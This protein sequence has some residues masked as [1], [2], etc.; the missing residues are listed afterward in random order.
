MGIFNGI[1]DSKAFLKRIVD[2]FTQVDNQKD[3][4]HASKLMRPDGLALAPNHK[5]LF[6]VYFTLGDNIP[7]VVQGDSGLIGALVKS[8]QLPSFRL[9]TKEYIQYN[10]KRLVHNRIEYDPVTI[11]FHDDASDTIR[12]LWYNYF[13]YYFADPSY[14]YESG[15]TP[16]E[17]GKTDYTGRDLYDPR[18]PRQAAGWGI[19]GATPD[20]RPVK[21]AFFKDI[22]IYGL[23][24]GNYMSYTLINPVITAWRHDTFDYSQS[25]GIMEHEMQLK[26]EAVKY[27]SGK[28]DD[29]G[30]I[31]VKGFAKESRY[32]TVPGV[33]GK[34][35]T[36]QIDINGNPIAGI[37][38]LGT[39]LASGNYLSALR[40]GLQGKDLLQGD[41]L[42][43]AIAGDLVGRTAS[44]L[45]NTQFD[46]PKEE[47][48]L[49]TFST[50]STPSA[51]APIVIDENE[52]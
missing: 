33:L 18:R 30:E 20:G 6:H 52:I 3:Y 26:Y 47:E 11:K 27:G 44:L 51:E 31:N 24:R 21:P 17:S 40:T 46:F 48:I 32:D 14:E 12:S 9:D 49:N 39:D 25:A 19:T 22:T 37:N 43:N 23:S 35:G 13:Q 42:K 5:F 4:S 50:P 15:Q 38:K 28:I 10:R 29:G 2:G 8:V 1:P 41:N 34:T 16:T 7:S 45:T 36:A